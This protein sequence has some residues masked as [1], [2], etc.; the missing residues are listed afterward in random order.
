MRSAE[1]KHMSCDRATERDV[2]QN[3]KERYEYPRDIDN[4]L[5]IFNVLLTVHLALISVK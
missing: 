3:Y 4:L 2:T 1:N 5:L